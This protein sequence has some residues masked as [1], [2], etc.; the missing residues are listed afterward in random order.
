MN[1]GCSRAGFCFIKFGLLIF[2]SLASADDKFAEQTLRAGFYA[3]AFPDFSVEDI[4][5]SVK[6]LAE[7][8]GKNVDIQTTVV[9]FEDVQAMNHAFEEGKINFAVASSLNIANEFNNELLADGFRL[10]ISGDNPDSILVMTRKNEGLDDIKS[11][12]GKKL[13]LVEYDPVADLYIDY[14]SKSTF[15]NKSYKKVFREIPREKK[16][17][18]II[19]KLFFGQTDVICV[20]QNAYVHAAELNPQLVSKLQIIKQLD[21]IPQGAGFFHKR[22]PAEFREKVIAEALKLDTHVRGQQ[23][24]Q[25]FKADKAIRSSLEDLV[26]TKKLNNEYQQLSNRK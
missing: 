21:G 3:R 10:Q 16:A 1:N 5:I 11:L 20:Y 9:V 7:E 22:V 12:M 13:G 4:E 24:L 25:L 6:L 14:L 8:I 17:N 2:L 15:N 18:Q 19:L 23:L 26:A